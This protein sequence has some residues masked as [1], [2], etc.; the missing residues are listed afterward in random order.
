MVLFIYVHPCAD[1]RR[2]KCR[3]VNRTHAQP[4]RI[5][6]QSK[7][8]LSYVCPPPHC[9]GLLSTFYSGLGLQMVN[10]VHSSITVLTRHS[11][12]LCH[13]HPFLVCAHQAYKHVYILCTYYLTSVSS[14]CSPSTR[15]RV[16][17]EEEDTCARQAR[18]RAHA[19]AF[20]CFCIHASI[21]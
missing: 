6:S 17:Y 11:S 18:D 4:K 16:S 14:L 9:P 20:L 1:E 2:C 13:R 19:W 15:P 12:C 3:R 10:D 21:H 8:R 7:H 5:T